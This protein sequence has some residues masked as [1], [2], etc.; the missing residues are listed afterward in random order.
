V[1]F[2]GPLKIRG[3]LKNS[4]LERNFFLSSVPLSL[5]RFLCFAAAAAAF[6]CEHKNDCENGL[7]QNSLQKKLK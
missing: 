4:L 7:S 5:F 6:A 3:S 1:R 2:G